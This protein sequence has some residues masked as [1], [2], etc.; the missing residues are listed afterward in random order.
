L[1]PEL[2]PQAEIVSTAA[3]SVTPIAPA[4][5][6]RGLRIVVLPSPGQLK[7]PTS[8]YLLRMFPSHGRLAAGT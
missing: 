6:H 2:E 1:E 3:I 4:V 8:C 5:P 7:K